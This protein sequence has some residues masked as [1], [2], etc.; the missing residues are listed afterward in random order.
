MLSDDLV[1]KVEESFGNKVIKIEALTDSVTL[2]YFSDQKVVLKRVNMKV[3]NIYNFIASQNVKNVV[4]PIKQFIFEKNIY[5][6]YTYINNFEYPIEK[7]I[8][9]LINN[10][11][12]LQSKTSFTVKLNDN[13]FKFFYR[14]Y[15]NLD[16]I[17]QTLEMLIR[18]SELKEQ[19]TDYDWIILSKYHVFIKC[20]K[21]MYEVQKKIHKYVSNH[22]SCIYCLNHGNLN[23]NHFIGGKML[24]FDN[25][26]IG[27]FVSDY[28]KL[29]LSLDEFDGEW[30]KIIEEKI[31]SY[32]N[33][34][35]LLY[36]KF[37]VLYI[38]MINIRF[39]SFDETIVLT[40]Y[41]QIVNKINSF[42]NLTSSY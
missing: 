23:L 39:T 35:Y 34:F 19:K 10:L 27:I 15:K 6:I 13:N 30:F 4:Y 41:L 16:R 38:Y 22:A 40:T 21:I 2:L 32:N 25:G 17:F 20:K 26:Y 18:E 8:I 36:F 31:K 28:A 33:D 3:K 7:K 24:S 29:Y 37:L 1:N 12:E 14:I 42:L 5:F 11:G 9:D